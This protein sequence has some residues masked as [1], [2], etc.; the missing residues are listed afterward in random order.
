MVNRGWCKSVSIVPLIRSCTPNLKLLTL[1][2]NPHY[3]PWEF[4]SVIISVVY[5]PP[6][7]D[8]DIALHELLHEALTQHQ[9]KHRDVVLIVAGDFNSANLKLNT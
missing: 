3:L 9:S 2:C 4:T 6:Q 1:K 5:I 7:A 8:M